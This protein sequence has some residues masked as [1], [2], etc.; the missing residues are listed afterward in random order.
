MKT[1]FCMFAVTSVLATFPLSINASALVSA[2]FDSGPSGWSSLSFLADPNDD[3]PIFSSTVSAYPVT[4]TA[5]GGDPGG[6]INLADQ[7]SGWQYFVASSAF[8]GNQSAAEG[9]T[10]SFDLLRTDTNSSFPPQSGP[11]LAITN[12]TLVLVFA[13]SSVTFPTTAGWTDYSFALSASAG[14]IFVTS[15]TG[16]HATQAQ[17]N[18][19]LSD[20]T[21][22]YILSDWYTG[23]G[24][25][26]NLDNVVLSSAVATPEPA[27]WVLILAGFTAVGL[28]GFLKRKLRS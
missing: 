23:I 9:G 13:P 11:P 8:L 25:S 6:A 17:I 24:D 28:Q 5:T 2:T 3:H 4:W 14:D 27:T 7:D 22:L 18:S 15:P 16:A 10:L 1:T 19:V 26:Y 21:G 20:L 12:G